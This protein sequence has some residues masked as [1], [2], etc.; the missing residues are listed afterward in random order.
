M[1]SQKDPR[2]ANDRINN[3][4][5]T[6]RTDGCLISCLA[7]IA[8]ITPA[9]ANKRLGF[10]GALVDWNKVGNI[11]LK[12]VERQ[13]SYDNEKAKATLAAGLFLIV[14]VD[15]DGNP[16]TASDYHFVRFLGNKQMGDPIDG[17]VKPTSSYRVLNGMRIVKKI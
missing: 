2:W 10:Y 12:L 4:K 5:Y 6:L 16:R 1:L 8:G 17:K 9:E 11:G 13:D 14:R 3:T 15:F 7:D